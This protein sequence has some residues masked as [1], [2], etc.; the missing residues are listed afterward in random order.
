MLTHEIPA[1]TS[2]KPA[3]LLGSSIPHSACSYFKMHYLSHMCSGCKRHWRV[4]SAGRFKDWLVSCKKRLNSILS[5]FSSANFTATRAWS[6][7]RRAPLDWPT[8][9]VFRHSFVRDGGFDQ[10]RGFRHC[11][12]ASGA[13]SEPSS[14]SNFLQAWCDGL[15]LEERRWFEKVFLETTWLAVGAPASSNALLLNKYLALNGKH[16]FDPNDRR[17]RDFSVL[18]S[19]NL[20][21]FLKWVHSDLLLQLDVKNTCSFRPAI[22]SCQDK[23]NTFYNST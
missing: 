5:V 19:V 23:V 21:V 6:M 22:I 9:L 2:S 11:S 20:W 15:A 14:A 13:Q 18:C 17:R 16:L 3:K 10:S 4:R 1:S 7:V 8:A 12:S